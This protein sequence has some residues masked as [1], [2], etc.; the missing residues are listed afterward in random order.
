L[1][2]SFIVNIIIFYKIISQLTEPIK[3][4]KEAIKSGSI[5]D[6]NIFKYEY[7]D[8]I[9]E[10]F[11][12]CKELLTGQI[13]ASNSLKYAGQFN[14]LNKQNDKDKI[15]DKN[16]YEKNLI[17]N[18]DIVNDLIN[19]QQNM[20]NFKKEIDV[21][22]EYSINHDMVD[23][24]GEERE[25]NHKK[26]TKSK[27]KLSNYGENEESKENKDPKENRESIKQNKNQEE[28]DRDKRSYKSMFRLAQ[29]LYY[30]R[31]KVEENNIVINTNTN[32]DDKK[33]NISKI[34]NNNQHPNSPRNQKHKKSI[35]SQISINDNDKSE[36]NISI[37]VL[38]DKDITYLWYMEMKKKNNKS[39]N[40]QLS[41]DLEELFTD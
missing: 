20:M 23:S 38:N 31:C 15:I 10:L 39:F 13:D 9:N 37:N 14:I 1:G 8:F 5:K 19:E 4:L 12:T 6:E 24:E 35:L 11:L 18:N 29:Y 36:D 26:T 30:Y 16:K 7:D 3:K 40:Y 41:D 28:E 25:P 34:N 21:N 2:F 33:S 27:S 32:N 22:D 17:I